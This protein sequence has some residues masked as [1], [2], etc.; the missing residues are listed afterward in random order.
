MATQASIRGIE[1][2]ER[3][4]MT[5]EPLPSRDEMDQDRRMREELRQDKALMDAF[6]A[7]ECRLLKDMG[8]D[9]NAVARIRGELDMSL[10]RILSDPELTPA[11][12]DAVVAQL[13]ELGAKLQRD[14]EALQVDADHRELI[15]QLSGALVALA[16]GMIVISNGFIAVGLTPASGGLSIGGA[17]LSAAVGTEMVADGVE[18]A[19]G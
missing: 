17:Y 2:L 5:R 4:V 12:R 6:I 16:G 14:L 9:T 8:V 19:R 3:D 15:Q 1:A 11:S 18:M 7:A 13:A 10:Q